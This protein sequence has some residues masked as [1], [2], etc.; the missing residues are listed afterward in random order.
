MLRAQ[1]QTLS[2]S[3]LLSGIQALNDRERKIRLT[4]LFHLREI[5]KRRLYLPLGYNSLF[6][7]CT[8]HLGY[9]RSSAYRRIEAARCIGRFPEAAVMLLTGELNLSV[10]TLIS[11]IIT[12]VNIKDI[13]SLVGGKSYRDAEVAVAMYK[14][15][16][17]KAWDRVKPVCVFEKKTAPDFEADSGIQNFDN[18]LNVETDS[19]TQSSGNSLNVETN[20]VKDAGSGKKTADVTLKQK[21][22]L[23]FMVD[24]AFMKKLEKVKSRLSRKYPG[25]INFEML[26]NI[27]MEEYLERHSPD[28]KIE[29]RKT[30]ESNK[31]R[32]KTTS[33]GKQN[34]I[35]NT[36]NIPAAIR[37]KIYKRDGGRCTFVGENGKRCNSTWNLEIDH[38]VPFARG[39]N[40]SPGNLRLLCAKHNF[41]EAARTYGKDFM[42]KFIKKE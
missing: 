25:G 9:S 23:E 37:D 1:L 5:D 35:N 2:D 18:S 22:K 12:K 14:P 11:G 39:G 29:R 26:F 38:I 16:E 19:V 42:G 30:H 4:V 24:P 41:M 13:L 27:I 17:T 8:R 32:L 6:E 10:L 34:R 20:S 15:I 33:Q 31:Q 40:N 21:F 3:K 28:N 7:F 36:R